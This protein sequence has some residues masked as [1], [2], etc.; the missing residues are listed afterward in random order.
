DGV[1]FF[2][3][4]AK[5]P[6]KK[7][8]VQVKGGSVHS[9]YIRDLGHVVEREKAALGFLI[10]LERPSKPMLTE[11]LST[12]VYHSPGWNRDYPRLQI[13]TIEQLRA[14]EGFEYPQANVTLPQAQ[15]V[16]AQAEQRELFSDQ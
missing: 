6:A 3:D 7:A 8:V 11:A 10:T 1:L 16:E 14:G 4:E 13:R 12:G 15:R 5:K 9:S 2:A